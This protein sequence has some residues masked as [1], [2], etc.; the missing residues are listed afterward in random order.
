[1]SNALFKSILRATDQETQE[2]LSKLVGTYDKS[3]TSTSANY[4]AYLN[5]NKGTGT[6]STTEERRIIKPEEFGTLED[7]VLLTPNGFSRI[8]KASYWKDKNFN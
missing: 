1:M 8:E 7:V 3:K 6:S 5:E 2:Y 4:G